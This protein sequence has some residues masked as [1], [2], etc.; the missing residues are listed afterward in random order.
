VRVPLRA[1]GSAAPAVKLMTSRPLVHP[2]GMRPVGPHTMLLAEGEGRLDEVTVNG[3]KAEIRVL[4]DSLM[5][6]PTAITVVGTKAFVLEAQLNYRNEPSLKD[7][8]PGPF[9]ALAVPYQDPTK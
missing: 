5:G 2:D 7:K 6:G 9:R 3:D 4:R 1:D 8:D